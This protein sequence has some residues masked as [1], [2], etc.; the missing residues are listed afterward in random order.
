MDPDLKQQPKL[1]DLEFGK[2]CFETLPKAGGSTSH[3][4]T[5]E[6]GMDIYQIQITYNNDKNLGFL[7]E[8][9][10]EDAKFVSL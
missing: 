9:P 5:G 3:K 4:R 10:L 7:V 6:E 2:Y 1:Q 8:L